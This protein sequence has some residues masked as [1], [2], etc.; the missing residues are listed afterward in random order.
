MASASEVTTQ[1]WWEAPWDTA[2][3]PDQG[4]P[5][6][7]DSEGAWHQSSNGL[8][9]DENSVIAPM[10]RKFEQVR[11]R[12]RVK[13]LAEVFTNDRE[14]DAMLDM[15][16]GAFD[17]LDVKFLEPSAGSGNFLVAILTRKLALARAGDCSTQEQYEHRLLRAIASIYGIDIAEDNIAEA[18]ARMAHELLTHYANDAPGIEPTLGFQNA[19]GLVLESNI[20]AGD[21]IN[22]AHSIELCDWKPTAGGCFQREWSYALIPY[23]ERGLFWE[24]RLEDAEPVHYSALTGPAP[25]RRKTRKAKAG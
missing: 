11:S 17:H 1:T 25:A 23:D 16:D 5:A 15:C 13:A 21:T 7:A 10:E 6:R 3:D 12:D 22:A 20:V 18:R 8:H 4:W 14:I 9:L 24:E 2:D 19:A